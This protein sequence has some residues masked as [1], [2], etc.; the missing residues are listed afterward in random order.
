MI[1]ELLSEYNTISKFFSFNIS[2]HKKTIKQTNAN[3]FL[4][5]LSPLQ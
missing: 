5:D 1:N 4:A 2:N 3:V